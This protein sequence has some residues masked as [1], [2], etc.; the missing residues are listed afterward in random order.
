MGRWD[1]AFGRIE[2][3]RQ[4]DPLSVETNEGLGAMYYWAGRLEEATTQLKKTLELEPN[5]VSTHDMLAEVYSRRGL[6]AEAVAEMRRAFVLNG[7]EDSANALEQDFKALGFELVVR[8]LHQATLANLEQKA[9]ERYVSPFYIA[10]A[11]AKLGEKDEAFAWLEKAF[12][13]RSAWLV[14]LNVDPDLDTL[15]SDPRLAALVK[16]IGLP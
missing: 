9:S 2:H 3:A 5:S 10:A 1:D 11:H 13:E 8:R 12:A 16:R 4:R 7:D 14:N 6:Q 15:R